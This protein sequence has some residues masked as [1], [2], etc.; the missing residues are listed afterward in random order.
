MYRLTVHLANTKQ[1]EVESKGKL[2]RKKIFNTRSY[3][4][5]VSLEAV[6]QKLSEIRESNTIATKNGK[7][8]INIILT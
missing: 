4:G 5:L 3:Y 1:E 6:N 8:L 2:T 7:E